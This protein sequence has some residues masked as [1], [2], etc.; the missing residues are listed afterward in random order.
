MVLMIL[1]CRCVGFFFVSAALSVAPFSA[2]AQFVP[3]QEYFNQP[4]FAT[5]NILP[6]YNAGLSGAGVRIGVVDSGINPNHL[7]FTQAIVAGYDSV[8]GRSGTSDLSSFLHDNPDYSNHGSFTASVVAGRLDGGARAD[9][10]QGVAYNAGIVIGTMDFDPGYFDRMAAALNYVSGQSVKVINNSWDTAEHIGN[11]ALDYQTLVQGGP[12]LISA[13]KTALDRGSVVVFTTGN[14]GAMT[15]ATPAVLPSFDADVAAK[16][17]F[18]VVGASTIDGTALA[19]YANRCGITQAYCLVAPGGSGDSSRPP[20]E[21]GVLGADGGTNRRY[22]NQAG[23]SAAAP[24]V[25][26]AVA[27]VAEQFPW[28]TNRNLATTILTTA[29]RAETPGDEWGRGLLN[30]GKAIGGPGIFEEDFTAHVTTGYTSIFSNNISGMA[31]LHKL[32]AGTLILSGANSYSGDTRLNGGDLVVYGQANLG[33]SDKAL[34]FDGGVLRF[35]ADLTL[36]RNLIIGP[37]GGTLDTGNHTLTYSGSDIRGGG[38]LT[39]FGTL[40]FVGKPLTLGSD[41]TLNGTWNADLL[42]PATLSLQGNGRVN[43]DLTI[44]GTLSPGNSI[45]TMTV[46]GSVLNQPSSRF[47]VEI[48]GAGHHDRLRLTGASSTYTADGGLVPLLLGIGGAASNTYQPAVGQGFEFVSAPGGVRGQ[49]S[50][51]TPPGVGLLPGTRMDL[52]YGPSALTLYATPASYADIGAAGVPDSATRRQV[53]AILEGMRPAPGLRESKPITKRLF[54]GLARQ[55]QSSLPLSMDQLGGVGYAQLIGMHVENTRFL[56]EQTMAAVSSQ[57]RGESAHLAGPATSVLAH[58]SEADIWSLALGRTSRWGGDRATYGISDTLGG[59]MG[60]VQKRLDAQTLAGVSLAYAG[61]HSDV[62]HN[63]GNGSAQNLQ[64]T[65][66]ASRSFEDGFFVQGALGGG[67]GRIQAKRSVVMLGKQYEATI[68]TTDLNVAVLTGW[69]SGA[70]D[71]VRYETSLGL[72]Y[73]ALRNL[74]F[75]DSASDAFGSLRIKAQTQESMSATLT[76]R[77]SVPFQAKGIHWR[78]A[79]LAGWIHGFAD[80]RTRVDSNVLGQPYS[81]VSGTV[82]R[83]RL[84]LGVAL[85]GNVTNRLRVGLD[86]G[87]QAARHWHATTGG[88]WVH[89]AF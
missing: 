69:A 58:D 70:R 77:I 21:Q 60:G 65:A 7:E 20:A 42:L 23:T 2:L 12:Q 63:I 29:S 73:L 22:Y 49:F 71:A 54:D 31:G 8:S 13:I 27:L 83:N 57:R 81:I 76:G 28:M 43:G 19:D 53:G 37:G 67:A 4:A 26:G 11:P 16:G 15:P 14:E 64:L 55:S 74:G 45:G 66:Y 3:G 80:S 85:S 89:L 36:D 46:S 48:D 44:A 87:R 62:E 10:M 32:G 47:V 38:T 9:N 35:G 17:G 24:I 6:A 78:A 84:S 56:T 59:L 1:R 25:S 61:S 75:R 18:I 50:S 82:G 34:Q 5:V 39:F 40:S 52:V 72:T 41:L 86:L 33:S 68:D 30:I 79:G 51:F 88:L